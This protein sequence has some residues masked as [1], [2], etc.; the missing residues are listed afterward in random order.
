VDKAVEMASALFDL[1]A[2]VIVDLHVEDIGDEVEGMLV[3]LDL[4]VEPSEVEAVG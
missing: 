2:H 3:V 4:R 1:L